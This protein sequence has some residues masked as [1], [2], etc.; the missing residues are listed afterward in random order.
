MIR[1]GVLFACCGSSD[2][3]VQFLGLDTI[4]AIVVIKIIPG[5]INANKI[6]LKI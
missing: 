6:S 3:D 5:L 2:E 1:D 4:R